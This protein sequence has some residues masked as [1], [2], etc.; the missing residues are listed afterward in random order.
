MVIIAP[1]D[2]YST[3]VQE[4]A[5]TYFV[6]HLNRKGT[7]PVRDIRFYRELKRIYQRVSPDVI[8][9]F[10]IKPNIYGSIAANSVGI[11][12]IAV[13]TGL[14]YTFLNKGL[15]ATA[16]KRLYKYAFKKNDLTI[17]QN[18]DDR[19]L[20]INLKLV[21]QEKSTVILGSGVDLN[22]FYP[23]PKSTSNTG[24][25]FLFIG[26]LLYDKGI[27]ELFEAFLSEFKQDSS[28]F[29]H[30]VGDIDKENPSAYSDE[31][32]Q[33]ML[34]G[35]KNI[36]YHGRMNALNE[37]ISNSDCV[38][39]PS[40]RE[41]LPRVMLEALAMAKPVI[42]TDVAGCREVVEQE[43]NGFL[44]KVNSSKDLA[45]AMKTM[46]ELSSLD[47]EKMGNKGLKMAKELFSANVINEQ[48]LNQIKQLF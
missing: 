34:K 31:S 45:F 32:L 11:P 40:Y 27:R 35:N 39:L 6:N 20:F 7:N 38:V 33:L 8:I 48:F 41:G 24:F 5:P 26:R 19:Q 43:E 47:R 25:H 42:T 36:I 44:V 18:P 21:S 10:T 22:K 12:S 28:T 30:L 9:H 1:K 17:F 16:A 37:I 13:V 2:E 4:L 23:L 3:A 46:K 29:L 15:A 14:G